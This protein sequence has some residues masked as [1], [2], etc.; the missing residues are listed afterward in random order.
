MTAGDHR[1]DAR[2]LLEEVHFLLVRLEALAHAANTALEDVPA[3]KVPAAMRARDR[4]NV[5]VELVAQDAAGLLDRLGYR[6]TNVAGGFGAWKARGGV[7]VT[8]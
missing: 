3:T 8:A 5:L 4:V 7:A 2:A 1:P 6:V